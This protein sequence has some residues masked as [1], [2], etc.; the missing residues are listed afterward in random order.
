MRLLRE[1]KRKM[2]KGMRKSIFHGNF[3]KLVDEV[4]EIKHFFI[5]L[6]ILSR[7][8]FDKLETN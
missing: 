7:M 4:I 6:L 1:M 3:M 2:G 5:F 8:L